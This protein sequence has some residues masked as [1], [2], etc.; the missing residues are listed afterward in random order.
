MGYV[1]KILLLIHKPQCQY[2]FDDADEEE[3]EPE[4]EPDLKNLVSQASFFG[5]S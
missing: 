4:P 2:G 1:R 5:S 3:D